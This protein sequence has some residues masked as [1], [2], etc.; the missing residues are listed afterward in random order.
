[1]KIFRY[2]EAGMKINID[3]WIDFLVSLSSIQVKL[4]DDLNDEYAYY[5]YFIFWLMIGWLL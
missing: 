4:F 3:N 1:M 2:C 5:Y